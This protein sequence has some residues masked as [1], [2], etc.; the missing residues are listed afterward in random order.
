[1]KLVSLIRASLALSACV[2]LSSCGAVYEDLDE[3]PVPDVAPTGLD[4]RLT[5][6]RT[7]QGG[8]AFSKAVHCAT[9]HLFDQQG[10]YVG[11]YPTIG[12]MV[13]LDLPAGKYRLIAYGGMDCDDA[14]YQ[15]VNHPTESTHYTDMLVALN[16]TRAANTWSDQLHP[17]FFGTAE[18]EVDDKE[19]HNYTELD[20]TKNTNNL[21]VVLQHNDGSEVDPN[22]FDFFITADNSTLNHENRIVAT[23]NDVAYRYW[24]KGQM[25]MGYI[26]GGQQNATQVVDAYAEIH[27]G[28]M[29]ADGQSPV[30]HVVDTRD[31]SQIVGIQLIDYFKLIKSL[32]L[33]DETL[34]D[35][36]DK[37]D[38][39]SIVFTL[40]ANTER[41]FGL[42]LKIN[43]WIVNLNQFDL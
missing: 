9:L 11:S 5:Y 4:T 42:T 29:E 34:Q 22:L 39:W 23:G 31:N 32:E 40:D 21:R 16:G 33:Q 3:C 7:I 17:H 14:S 20:L 10:L 13:S 35:Y 37:Q 8:D 41:I 43:D 25:P 18:V 27:F 38:Q 26:V 30:L 19:G 28:P 12:N 2:A 6:T 15:L 1:M 24:T 36:L